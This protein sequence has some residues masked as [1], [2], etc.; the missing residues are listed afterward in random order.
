M[1]AGFSIVLT[2]TLLAAA[3]AGIARQTLPTHTLTGK[4][5][6]TT[7]VALSDVTV[8][9]SRPGES[10]TVR[11]VV[12]DQQGRYRIDRVLPGVYVLTLRLAGFASAIR[13]IEIGGG[14]QQFEYDV[15]LQ[16]RVG[17][18]APV[19]EAKPSRRVICGMTVITPAPHFDSKIVVPK[20]PP[21]AASQVKPTIRAVQ[22]TMCWEK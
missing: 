2:L 16:A 14:A 22:P 13:D 20:P 15:Q 11:T 4:V 8:E 21:P 1:L 18:T 19:S 10:G 5:T 6:D 3:D 7:G 17:D 9:L 12:T